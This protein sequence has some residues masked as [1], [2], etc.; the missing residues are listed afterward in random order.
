MAYSTYF[1]LEPETRIVRYVGC[2]GVRLLD[3]YRNHRSLARRRSSRPLYRWWAAQAVDPE[4]VEVTRHDTRR[5]ALAM[6][7]KL[8]GVLKP[9]GN[10][11]RKK[12]SNHMTPVA[13]AV[14]DLADELEGRN[15][16]AVAA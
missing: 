16:Q 1:L 10:A 9:I 12:S 6:E 14:Y 4:I 13:R 15:A 5:E 8:I 3:R 7:R 11:V 2:S